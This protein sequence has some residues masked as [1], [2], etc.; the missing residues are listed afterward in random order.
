[1]SDQSSSEV[2]VLY[3]L[4]AQLM[5]QSTKALKSYFPNPKLLTPRMGQGAFRNGNEIKQFIM[6]SRGIPLM[7]G[8][9]HNAS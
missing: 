3:R 8:Q 1:M 4:P 5:I 6:K 2:R 9:F 7:N